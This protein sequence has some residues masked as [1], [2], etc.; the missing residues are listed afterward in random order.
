M[1]KAIIEK[2]KNPRILAANVGSSPGEI[3]NAAT[4]AKRLID[5]HQVSEA[6]LRQSA[7]TDIGYLIVPAGNSKPQQALL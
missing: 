3:V 4:L 1:R 2:I 6:E 7:Q 5:E